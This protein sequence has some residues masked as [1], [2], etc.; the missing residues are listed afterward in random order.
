[1]AHGFSYSRSWPDI[2]ERCLYGGYLDL[3]T[4]TTSKMVLGQPHPEHNMNCVDLGETLCRLSLSFH[5]GSIQKS[6]LRYLSFP[7]ITEPA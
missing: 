1:M 3:G 2:S 7:I 4:W 6:L 5:V